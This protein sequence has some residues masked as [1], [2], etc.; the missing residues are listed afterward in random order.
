MSLSQV[1]QNFHEDSENGIN[2]QINMEL[3]ASYVYL[4]MAYY[5]D[6]DDVALHGISE[7]FRKSSD[8]EREHAQKLM[9]YL[10]KRGGRIVLF[11]VKQ[12]PRN[13]WG[14]AEEAFTAALQLEKDVNTSLLSLHQIGT[15]HNDANFCDYL[16]SEFLQEQVDSIKSIGD[17]L[18]NI[19][20]VGKEGLGIFI[21]D[22]ELK[23]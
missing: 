1:R 9:K 8:E 11:D 21:F 12:P 14:N 19:R 20:R 3:Y 17:M 7:Y 10:N 15:V 18:T 5:F 6:R 13:D 16:E 2:K 4:S 22:K 23:S